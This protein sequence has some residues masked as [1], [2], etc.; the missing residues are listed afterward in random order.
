MT[1]T[2]KLLLI[3]PN[4]VPTAI[5]QIFIAT[6][7]ADK[8]E[9]EVVLERTISTKAT[10]KIIPQTDEIESK[11]HEASQEDIVLMEMNDVSRKTESIKERALTTSPNKQ[12]STATKRKTIDKG[13]ITNMVTLEMHNNLENTIN[14]M[15]D[16]IT[17][18]AKQYEEQ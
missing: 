12:K 1:I 11:H 18:F 15:D 10:E 16:K 8:T 5:P 13:N 17:Q 4:W 2:T 14:K 9:E 6:P 3:Q 7:E